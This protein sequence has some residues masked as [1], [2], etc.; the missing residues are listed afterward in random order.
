MIR[1]LHDFIVVSEPIREAHSSGLIVVAKDES[2]LACYVVAVGPG[3][4]DDKGKELKALVNV[5]DIVFLP[6]EV[7][8][9]APTAKEDGHV[10]RFIKQPQILCWETPAQ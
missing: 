1:A 8:N 7:V 6:K 5:G 3:T 10:Y 4:V 2:T 9:N